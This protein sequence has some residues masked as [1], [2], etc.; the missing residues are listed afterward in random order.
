MSVHLEGRLD[1]V[2]KLRDGQLADVGI[3]SSRPRLAQ[4]LMAGTTPP[5]A[6]ERA[7][8][9]FSLCGKA[10]RVAAQAAC[11]AAQGMQPDGERQRSRVQ[12][13]LIELAQEHAAHLLLH[14]PQQAGEAVDMASLLVLRQAATE[15]SRFSQTLQRVL[16]EIMLGEAASSWLARDLPAFDVWRE[17]AATLPA[18]L[19]RAGWH[20]GA[21]Q[22]ISQAPLLPPLRQLD[23]EDCA[24]LAFKALAN[25]AFCGQPEWAGGAAET[26]AIARMRQHPM[27]AGWIARR[28][29]GSGAR[30]LAR[31]LELASLPPQLAED[32]STPEGLDTV[33]KSYPLAENV[34]M[35]A[36]E[37][38]RGLLIHV[39][40][41]SAGK[42]AD[43]RIVAPTEW[44]FHPAGALVE[45]LTQAMANPAPGEVAATRAEAIC[46][47]L[48]PCVSFAVEV[49][50]A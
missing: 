27:L 35:S 41:L 37:T 15:P 16:H 40:R 44:N 43:Y 29:R 10:Q 46:Q 24:A 36:I 50:H 32:L 14:W 48:D 49:S 34:G 21:D 23:I 5:Q 20:A 25:E 38:S 42:V 12:R 31:L 3:R 22:G 9:I 6:A 19:F 17:Q 2:L 7:G 47:S 11:E 13:V 1:I 8:L 45:A 30:L 26:G 18:R 4:K 33:V 39:V 28:G